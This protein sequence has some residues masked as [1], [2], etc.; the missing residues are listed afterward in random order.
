MKTLDLY[1]TKVCNLNCDYCYVDLVSDEK[2]FNKGT[3]SQR[4]DL[5]A[6]DHIKFF[7]GEPLLK[8]FEIKEIVLEVKKNKKNTLFTIVTNGLL[9]DEKKLQFCLNNNVEVVISLHMKGIKVLLKKLQKF[10][11]AKKI[12]WFSIIFE[13]NKIMY[14]YQMISFLQKCW[15]INFIIT[16]EI[17]SNWNVNQLRLLEKEL[18]KCKELF[19]SN[20][21]INFRWVD[22]DNLKLLVKWCEKIIMWKTWLVYPCNRFNDLNNL[23]KYNYKYIFD[24]F[25]RIIDYDNDKYKWF[26]VCPIGWFLD[27][28]NTEQELE[29]RILQYKKLNHVFIQFYKNINN[30]KWKLNFLSDNIEEIRFNL[31]AQCNIRCN[32]CY[33]DFKNEV[34][35]E[36]KAK[37]IIDFYLS[38]N[39]IKKTISFFWWEPLLEFKL[40]Q[41]LVNYANDISVEKKKKVHFSIATNFLL[42]NEEKVNFLKDNNF[43]IHIS[44]NWEEDTNDS[45]RDSSNKMLMW[46]LNQYSNMIWKNNITILLAFSNEEV[47]KLY[48]N[49]KYIY[50]LGYNQI[51]LEMIFGKNYVWNKTSIHL[52][53]EEFIKIRASDFFNDLQLKNL[54]W[55]KRFLDISVDWKA[56][57]N[58]F[59]FHNYWA[60]FKMKKMFDLLVKKVF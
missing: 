50:N 7:W 10:L 27:S 20:R 49:L 9:L 56:W 24:T 32:Y 45:M 35:N 33:V 54:E 51:N 55:E 13:Q 23:K 60:N 12:V 18:T 41:N 14:P 11:F 42:V 39:G 1:I 44:L 8:W 59:D 2:N 28:L 21:S 6:Y 19:I 34:L 30:I 37:N 43:Q 48:L 38:Q 31:T 25:N 26:Y 40:L 57:E 17:Y 22:E 29:E 58:S 3:F 52:L 36:R 53:I 5:L 15:F 46:K 47:E 4:I 16:P